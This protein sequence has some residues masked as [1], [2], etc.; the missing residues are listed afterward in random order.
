MVLGSWCPA[1][2]RAET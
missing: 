2:V 1:T